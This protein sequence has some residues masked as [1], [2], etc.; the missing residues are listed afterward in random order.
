VSDELHK[1]IIRM[2]GKPF[3]RIKKHKGEDW[4]PDQRQQPNTELGPWCSHCRTTHPWKN[5]NTLGTQYEKRSGVWW[6]LWRCNKSGNIIKEQPVVGRR[7][8]T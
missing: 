2:G 1:G 7:N 3:R 4:K 5:K 6:I 8:I